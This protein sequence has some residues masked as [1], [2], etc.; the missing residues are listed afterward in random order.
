LSNYGDR[1]GHPGEGLEPELRSP[2]REIS[3]LSCASSLVSGQHICNCSCLDAEAH[4]FIA[5]WL[6]NRPR[7]LVGQKVSE[8]VA[9]FHCV[10]NDFG[11]KARCA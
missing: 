6:R 1:L 9:I 5:A 11:F 4:K 8:D 7:R 3:R 10:F 2:R